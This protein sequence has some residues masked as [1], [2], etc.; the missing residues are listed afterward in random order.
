LSGASARPFIELDRQAR[1]NKRIITIDVLLPDPD[2]ERLV[3]FYRDIL[4]SLGEEAGANPLLP[5]V[6][7]TCNRGS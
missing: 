5:N 4:K 1:E 6:L 2:E 3:K 7:A